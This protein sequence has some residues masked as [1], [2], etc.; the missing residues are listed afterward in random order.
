M[1]R[2]IYKT[3]A[4]RKRI[5]IYLLLI[6]PA[7]ATIWAQSGEEGNERIKAQKVA[8]ITRSVNLTSKEAQVFWPVYNEYD[9]K[10]NSILSERRNAFTYFNQNEAK[11]SEKETDE[12]ISTFVRL[13]KEESSLFEEYNAKFLKI[14]AAKKVMKLYV[15]EVEFKNYLLKQIRENRSQTNPS[16]Q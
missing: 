9:Q 16:R 5:I 2:L 13:Q 8:F 3:A 10:R 15:A 7:W 12:I 4:M 6:F 1:L 11:L 14:L